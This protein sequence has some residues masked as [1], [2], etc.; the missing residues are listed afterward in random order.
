MD[1]PCVSAAG[2]CRFPTDT[3]G[4]GLH[5]TDAHP[6]DSHPGSAGFC[7]GADCGLPAL[8]SDAARTCS[9]T[10]FDFAGFGASGAAPGDGLCTGGQAP[11]RSGGQHRD[12]AKR[13][14]LLHPPQHPTGEARQPPTRGQGR[15]RGRGGRSA[16]ARAL[17]RAHG[18]QWQPSFQAGRTD[19]HV[20]IDRREARPA[21]QCLHRVRR[22]G[23]HV[24]A[25]D[26]PRRHRPQGHPGAVGLC[27]RPVTRPGR[28]RQ[29][30]R[31][32]NRGVARRVGRLVAAARSADPGALL[33]VEVRRAAA[34]RKTGR[35]PELHARSAP[36]LLHQMVSARPH[37]AHRRR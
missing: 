7:R 27:R 4:I 20:R 15:L 29:G 22:D 18:V 11:V 23:V 10:P 32:R 26:R 12:A 37:G 24:H 14:H 13:A 28:D 36:C 31:G 16:G 1:R 8:G 30:A 19:L 9:D 5:L 33:Q 34:D 3:Y 25:A 21:R 2:R 35:A 6:L 17:R